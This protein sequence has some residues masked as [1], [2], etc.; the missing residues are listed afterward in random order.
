MEFKMPRSIRSAS[1]ASSSNF[2][3]SSQ[4]ESGLRDAAKEVYDSSVLYHG[5]KHP[6]LK[7]LRENGFSKSHKRDG[8]TAGGNANMF[9]NLSSAAHEESANNHYL[10]SS[11]KE[12]KNFAMFADMDNPALLRTI[13]V[14]SSFNLISDPRT[15]GTAY[16]TGQSIPSKF[17]LGR[18]NSSPGENAQVFK[19]EMHAAGYEVS[20]EQAGA[21]L[22]DVQSDSDDDNFPDPDDFIMSRMRGR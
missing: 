13:G 22:R 19:K 2:D 14:R 6:H 11:K 4:H 16:M 10:S 3:S 21:L 9:M 17:V 20:T 18:K 12:A 7:S 1:H 8:A 15:G 5:T